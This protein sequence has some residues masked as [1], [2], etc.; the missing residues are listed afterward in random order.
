MP[1]FVLN[2]DHFLST[3]L[4]H[5]I[6]IKKGEP[7]YAAPAIVPIVHG[8]GAEQVPEE[9]YTDPEQMA[10]EVAKAAQAERA[11][12]E[13]DAK[14]RTDKIN[15]AF[16]EILKGSSRDAFD[17]GGRPHAKTVSELIGFKI[18]AAERDIAWADYQKA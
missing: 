15:A 2:R 12:I 9:G 13:S 10:A 7:F 8:L 5:V 16:D 4:G 11:R 17:A 6:K 14:Y 1:Q 18:T 3:T